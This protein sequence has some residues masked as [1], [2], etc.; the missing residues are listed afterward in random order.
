LNAEDI[1]LA[2]SDSESPIDIAV[3]FNK[4]IAKSRNSG[5]APTNFPQEN[6]ALFKDWFLVPIVA[7]DKQWISFL[8]AAS[9]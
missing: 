6:A 4:L 9:K 7:R 3:R 8:M 1:V 5:Q 2:A